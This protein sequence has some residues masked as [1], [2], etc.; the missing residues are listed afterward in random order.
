MGVFLN[1]FSGGPGAAATRITSGW[2]RGSSILD[3]QGRQGYLFAVAPINVLSWA[4]LHGTAKTKVTDDACKVCAC[5]SALS[6]S[7]G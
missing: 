3:I 5:R 7:N 1:E 6:C 2:A 4:P